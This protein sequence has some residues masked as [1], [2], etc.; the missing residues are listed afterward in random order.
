[1]AMLQKGLKPTLESIDD[2]PEL[3]LDPDPDPSAMEPDTFEGLG[4]RPIRGKGGVLAGKYS[5][6]HGSV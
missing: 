3:E 4:S 1:M 2:V 6:N 5:S